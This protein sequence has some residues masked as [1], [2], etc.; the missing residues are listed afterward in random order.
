MRKNINK[1][2]DK[3]NNINRHISK[4]DEEREKK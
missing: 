2:N 1:I 4:V 3:I